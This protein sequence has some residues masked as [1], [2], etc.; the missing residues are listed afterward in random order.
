VKSEILIWASYY[1]ELTFSILISPGTW[2]VLDA[3]LVPLP[4]K[5]FCPATGP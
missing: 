5:N 3:I 1:Q 2:T 4:W